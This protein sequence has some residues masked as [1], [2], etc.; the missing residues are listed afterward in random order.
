M[1]AEKFFWGAVGMQG[2]H[3]SRGA[4]AMALLLVALGAL[5]AGTSVAAAASSAVV[6]QWRFDE[7]GGQTA[8]DDGPFGLD[9]RLGL[10]GGADASDPAR[11]AGSSG[12]ALRFN[13]DTFVRLPAAGE[14][15]PSTLTLE[16]VVRADASPGRFRYLISHGAQGC[17]AGSYGLYTGEKGGVAFYVFDGEDFHVTAAAAPADVW[18]GGWHH[19]A[20]TF[21]G[22]ALRLFVDGHPVGQPIAAPSTIAYALTSQ[23]HY[24]GTYQGTCALPLTGDIDLIRMWRG[25]LSPD[26]IGELSD[27]A[28]APPPAV[29]PPTT[30]TPTTVPTATQGQSQGDAPAGRSTLAPAADGTSAP[31]VPGLS[32]GTSP[33]TTPGA[34][35]RAC[36]VTPASK[37]VR[38][39]RTTTVTVR[40][41]LRGKPLKAVRVVALVAQRTLAQA[42]TARDGRAKLRVKPSTRTTIRLKVAGRVDCGSAV[43]SVLRAA[44]KR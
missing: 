16:A 14:L 13:G 15:E 41:A 29:V 31:G 44:R 21:D 17:V 39:G 10:S 40:V 12:G 4:I 30:P 1:Q 19:V 18:N 2:R 25:P 27:A 37:R 9:G 8:V 6:G 23:D 28:L 22:H 36:V 26:F 42:K 33:K 38:A 24:F 3:G 5:N 20:G 7:G 43:L 32:A 11:I 34:P 35:A